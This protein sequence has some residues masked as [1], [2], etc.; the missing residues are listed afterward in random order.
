MDAV[1][2]Q[3]EEATSLIQILV[4]MFSLKLIPAIIMSYDEPTA[5]NVDNRI[6]RIKMPFNL[7]D[8]ESIKG[9]AHECYHYVEFTLK[10]RIESYSTEDRIIIET[11]CSEYA[12]KYSFER[13][14]SIFMC[15]FCNYFFK[16]IVGYNYE[17]Q[18]P[19]VSLVAKSQFPELED[20]EKEM[21]ANYF[22]RKDTYFKLFDQ[23][24]KESLSCYQTFYY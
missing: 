13:D 24:K 5:Y 23:Y 7:C 1:Q 9:I 17:E 11:K 22:E 12:Y 19:D 6:I 3:R 2:S 10:N 8:I 18:L 15:L 14:A 16:E 21:I 20:F 4:D